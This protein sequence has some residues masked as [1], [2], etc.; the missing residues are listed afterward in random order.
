MI[1]IDLSESFELLNKI[2]AIDNG[3]ISSK[4]LSSS[5]EIIL[6]PNEKEIKFT[7]FHDSLFFKHDKWDFKDLEINQNDI[8]I[9][10]PYL[11]LTEK[12]T[13]QVNGKIPAF[14]YGNFNEE[15]SKYQ[16]LALPLYQNL[17]FVFS[18]DNVL[19]H[20]NY[21][22]G[23]QTI[24]A[25][26]I[27]INDNLFYLFIAKKK[28]RELS[29]RDY[30]VLESKYPMTYSE[31]TECCFSILISFG[32][33][34]GDFIN[35]EGYFLQYENESMK[36]VVGIAYR[37][38]NESI[39]CQYVPIHSNPSAYIHNTEIANL[40]KDNVRKLNIKE[41]SKL[42]QYCHENGDIK[43]ILLGLIEVHNQ[44]LISAPEILSITLEKLANI[45]YE[46]NESKLVPIKDK[47][48]SKKLR[49]ELVKTLDNFKKE[50]DTEGIKIL[51]SKIKN[52]NQITNR[53][54]LLIPFEILNIPISPKDK[55]AI[56]ERNSLL[57]GK[58]PMFQKIESGSLNE[59]YKLRY[60]LFLKLYVLVSSIIMKSIGYD[61]LVV[62]YP[63][64]YEKE[65][66][67]KL[68]EEYYRQI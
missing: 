50:I 55:D 46:K 2:R 3:I 52:I 37:K 49:S 4:E 11:Y 13:G 16:R 31:F 58:I 18:I 23:I 35:N 41:F 57:H 34:S 14:E 45:F 64:I 8:K 10:I 26:E 43:S 66:G 6:Q 17:N 24:E 28:I 27:V 47:N 61:N 39:H 33:V 53:D 19:I 63:K 51:E 15:E 36:N 40:Y 7:L 1:E 68:D 56:E 5:Y 9:R 44:S 30:L 29:D 32:F 21:K 12:K 25:I 48:I 65:T 38:M 67:I 60:Y 20:Y 62:N 54:K 59:A 22:S 42:C